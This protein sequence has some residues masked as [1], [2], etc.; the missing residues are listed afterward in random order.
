MDWDEFATLAVIHFLAVLS[1]GP[2][3]ISTMSNAF[4]C[5]SRAGI[6]T[7]LG[8]TFGNSVH[9]AF[10]IL[11]VSTLVLNLPNIASLLYLLGIAYLLYIGIKRIVSGMSQKFVELID[12]KSR[13]NSNFILD[14]I[15][16]NITNV[17]GGLFFLMAYT[18]LISPLNPVGMKIFYG[19]W[20]MTVN[21]IM[22]SCLAVLIST[23]NKITSSLGLNNNTIDKI[24][25]AGFIF[26]AILLSW[27][28]LQS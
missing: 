15:I 27:N 1:P 22:L 16:I 3:V 21:F 6:M 8:I 10:S 26:V 9:I 7:A 24:S 17:K 2:N 5:G 14:G 25:G 19:I 11:G 20:M 28:I 4:A 12:K 13:N 23:N 18:T